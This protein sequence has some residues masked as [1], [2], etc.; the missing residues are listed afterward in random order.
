MFVINDKEWALLIQ[1]ASSVCGHPRRA[2]EGGTQIDLK[3]AH[4]H[5]SLKIVLQRA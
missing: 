4:S 3:T 1:E 2:D 5:L